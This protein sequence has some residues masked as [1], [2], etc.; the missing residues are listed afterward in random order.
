M[1]SKALA[2]LSSQKLPRAFYERGAREVAQD[3]IGCI[4]VHHTQDGIYQ[5]RII[6]TEAYVGPHDLACHASKGRTKRTEIMF[7]PAGFAYVYLIYGMY[8]LLNVV[9]SEIGDP[10][11][12]LIRAGEPI[13]PL[14]TSL[15]GPGKFTRG[16][17]ITRDHYGEDFC[18]NHL[19]FIGGPRPKKLV[20][21][22]RV[23]VDYAK[24]WKD[25]A[26]RFYEANNPLVSVLK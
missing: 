25:K 6:E 21:A 4:L 11:A 1:T 22:K 15:S 10:Q 12:V 9:T 16:M 23:G 7:G 2:Q 19:F 13:S 5:S 3:L 14:N 20:K 18:S 26:L 17:K 24:A 8:E